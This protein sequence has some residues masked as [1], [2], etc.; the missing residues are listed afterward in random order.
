LQSFGNDLASIR[1]FGTD[2]VTDMC[3][4]LLEQGAPGLHFYTMNR[5][6]PTLNIWDRLGL[7]RTYEKVLN[8]SSTV[9]HIA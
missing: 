2:V 7:S 6:E 9:R 8:S 4:R 1:E 3:S 5:A